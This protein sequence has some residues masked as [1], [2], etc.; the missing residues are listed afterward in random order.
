MLMH[1]EM[2]IRP[3]FTPW[4]AGVF[5]APAHRCRGIGRMLAQHVISAA[6]SL[7]FATVYLYTPT[8]EAYWSRLGWS[9]VEHAR[10]R[11]TDVTVML[12][13]QVT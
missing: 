13:T 7:R 5:V 4:L 1:H 8:A 3:Q 2:D 11:D 6:S 10:F 9:V 12:H